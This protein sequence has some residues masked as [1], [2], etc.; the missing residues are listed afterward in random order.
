V[1]F[2]GTADEAE[3]VAEGCSDGVVGTGEGAG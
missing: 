3:R 2:L 1:V